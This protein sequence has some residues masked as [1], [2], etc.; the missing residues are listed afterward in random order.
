MKTAR[1]VFNKHTCPLSVGT[2]VC[3][4]V[5]SLPCSYALYR[6]S[7]NTKY[8]NRVL[9]DVGLCICVFDVAEVGEGKV[10]YGDGFLRYTG[11]SSVVVDETCP[12]FLIQ[13]HPQAD[14]IFRPFPSEV[15]LAKV[16][17]SDEDGIQRESF[18]F[19]KPKVQLVRITRS[20]YLHLQYL[21]VF[22][23]TCGYHSFT[24]P[25]HAPCTYP[26]FPLFTF[27]S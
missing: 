17:S 14:P 7:K 20:T 5:C 18:S 24:V 16:K 15:V 1:A 22:S 21:S 26:F 27:T 25:S 6:H 2:V 12:T 23:K 8:A 3:L 10:R 13:Y 4:F 11:E 9:H 19:S